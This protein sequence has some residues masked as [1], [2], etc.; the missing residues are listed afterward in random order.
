MAEP[1]GRVLLV[2]RVDAGD[3]RE[4]GRFMIRLAAELDHIFG[5]AEDAGSEALWNTCATTAIVAINAD[6]KEA[7]L[8]YCERLN[9]VLAALNLAFPGVSIRYL[10]NSKTHDMCGNNH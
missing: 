8:A 7:M 5:E 6:D 2:M 10:R 3:A 9:L 1:T 4:L